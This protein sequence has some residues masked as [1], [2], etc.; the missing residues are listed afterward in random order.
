[1]LYHMKEGA[2][3]IILAFLVGATLL[4]LMIKGTTVSF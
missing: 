2:A 4:E 3:L 1:V